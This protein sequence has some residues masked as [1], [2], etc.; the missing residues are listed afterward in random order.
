MRLS[1]PGILNSVLFSTFLFSFPPVFCFRVEMA[2]V[3]LHVYDLSN[4]LAKTMSMTFLGMTH[5]ITS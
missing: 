1:R 4:G 3:S 2:H 5:E